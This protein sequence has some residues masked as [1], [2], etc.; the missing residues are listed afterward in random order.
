M[1]FTAKDKPMSHVSENFVRTRAIS[2]LYV[3]SWFSTH[4]KLSSVLVEPM[5]EGMNESRRRLGRKGRYV[6]YLSKVSKVL[7]ENNLINS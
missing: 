4:K 2:V 7:T 1:F 6:W 5:N 3:F